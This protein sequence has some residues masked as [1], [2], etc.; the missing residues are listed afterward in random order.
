MTLKLTL[1][2]KSIAALT[3]LLIFAGCGKNEPQY[4]EVEEVQQ[5][6][7]AEMDPHAGH[8][9]PPGEHPEAP[10]AQ[11]PFSYDVPEGWNETPPPSMVLLAMEAGKPPQLVANLGVSAF[12]GDVGGQLA[13]INRW[14]RQVGL[15]PLSPDAVDGFVTNLQV[16]GMDAWQVDFTGPSGTGENGGSARVVVTALPHNGH[17]W[18][19]KL[20][21]NDS[22]V[23]EEL[24]KYAAFLNSVQF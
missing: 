9:H 10:S 18:F 2:L 4:V 24:D 17:T 12:P 16:S 13:N 19:F 14:R 7:P 3:T 6:Q 22:A 5:E 8:N 11:V 21:G 23:A 15:G 20:M 1:S